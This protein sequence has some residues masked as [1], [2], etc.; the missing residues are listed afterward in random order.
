MPATTACSLF[1]AWD[2]ARLEAFPHGRRDLLQRDGI[3]A[4]WFEPVEFFRRAWG[5]SAANL[6]LWPDIAAFLGRDGTG[7]R[8]DV[9]ESDL[10]ADRLRWCAPALQPACTN[11]IVERDLSG[12]PALATPRDL[13]VEPAGGPGMDAFARVYLE[14]F[15]ARPAEPDDALRN[16]K[17]LERIPGWHPW[18]VRVGSEVAGA[19]SLFLR[20]GLAFLSSGA[21]LPRFE[22][23]GI[24]RHLIAFR[25]AAA[26]Q[27]GASRAVSYAQ[28]GSRS[29]ANLLRAGFDVVD[30]KVTLRHPGQ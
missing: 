25:L 3:T 27:L 13:A 21:T 20:D 6:G 14:C 8:V 16:L 15:G 10:A 7:Y 5:W 17:A 23:R 22:G 26:R 18:L 9:G 1:A 30:A 2:L 28:R 12:L 4:I 19:Y 24:Q 29:L 11:D